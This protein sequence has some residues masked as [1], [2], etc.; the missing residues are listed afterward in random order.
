[1][2]TK[3]KRDVEAFL[4]Q[5]QYDA[6]LCAQLRQIKTTGKERVAEI[7]RMATAAGFDFSTEE[8]EEAVRAHLIAKGNTRGQIK[9]ERITSVE[10]DPNCWTD[11]GV[12]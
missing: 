1:M 9:D 10:V 3:H 5:A 8:Y 12:G 11:L 2:D 4:N 7:V 6:P